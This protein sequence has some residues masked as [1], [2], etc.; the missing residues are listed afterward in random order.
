MKLFTQSV[1]LAAS[2]GMATVA[3]A[4]DP[5]VGKWLTPEKGVM[6]NITKSGSQFTGKLA[7]G[8]FAGHKG[9]R[10]IVSKGGNKYQGKAKHPRWGIIPA[11]NA[12]ITVNGNKLTIKTVKGTQVWKKQ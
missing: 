9:L 12:N 6:V 1:V 4:A 2:L 11:V 7:N 3:M 5:I 8:E 10:N